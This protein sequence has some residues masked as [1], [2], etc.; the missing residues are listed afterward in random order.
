MGEQHRHV[1]RRE[2]HRLLTVKHVPTGRKPKFDGAPVAGLVGSSPLAAADIRSPKATQPVSLH[3]MARA[4]PAAGASDAEIV[5]WTFDA[6]DAR[7]VAA[8]RTVWTDATVERFPSGT[9]HGADGM[10]AYFERLFA[11]VPDLRMR[12]IALAE[13]GEDV[14]VHWRMT[15]THTGAPYEGIDATGKT[16]AIDGMDHFVIRDGTIATN[17]VVFD[18]MQFARQIGMLPPDGSAADRAT[19]AAFNAKTRLLARVRRRR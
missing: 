4:K 11:A 15:G 12:V 19:K 5:R 17:F 1:G 10:S 6:I 2:R 13:N 14:F 16:L 7:D 8:L 3:G 18:Q 9:V